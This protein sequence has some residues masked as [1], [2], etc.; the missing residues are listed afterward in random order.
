MAATETAIKFSALGGVSKEERAVKLIPTPSPR[1]RLAEQ[2]QSQAYN[3]IYFIALMDSKRSGSSTVSQ[4][5]TRQADIYKMYMKN[6]EH[7]AVQEVKRTL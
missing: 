1:F 2:T 7:G 3:V 5:R 6:E 4:I